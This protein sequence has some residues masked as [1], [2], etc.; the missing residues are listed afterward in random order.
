[1]VDFFREMTCIL[2]TRYV[3]LQSSLG[4]DSLYML[5][6]YTSPIGGYTLGLE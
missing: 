2:M 4:Y 3:G 5:T 1:M 6:V